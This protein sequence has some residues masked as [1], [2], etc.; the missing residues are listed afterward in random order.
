MALTARAALELAPHEAYAAIL[1]FT[2]NLGAGALRN[3]SW[4]R[5]FKAATRRRSKLLS[6]CGTKLTAKRSRASSPGARWKSIFCSGANGA[7]TARSSTSSTFH[8]SS[9]EGST[10]NTLSIALPPISESI[11][12]KSDIL[13]IPG[14]AYEVA[15]LTLGQLC[16]IICTILSSATFVSTNFS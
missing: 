1:S 8:R 3:A 4:V 11:W 9:P 12:P 14:D 7:T 10:R 13:V 15:F 6:R 2:W 16:L 5:H